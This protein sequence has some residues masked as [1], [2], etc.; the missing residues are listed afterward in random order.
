MRSVRAAAMAMLCVTEMATGTLF[1]TALAKG[2]QTALEMDTVEPSRR[3]PPMQSIELVGSRISRHHT[4]KIES[5][6]LWIVC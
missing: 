5:S 2:A 3:R 6:K 4:R 1:I